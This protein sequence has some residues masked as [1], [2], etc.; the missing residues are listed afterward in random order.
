MYY[1]RHDSV[2]VLKHLNGLLQPVSILQQSSWCRIGPPE[3]TTISGLS[4]IALK[5]LKF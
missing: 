5:R 1:L 2:E 3:G 4:N